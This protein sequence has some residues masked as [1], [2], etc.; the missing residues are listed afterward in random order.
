MIRI[1][2]ILILLSFLQ[3]SC[4]KE[5][6]SKNHPELVGTWTERNGE[7]TYRVLEIANNSGGTM[8]TYFPGDNDDTQFRK[9]RI[10]DNQLFYGLVNNLGE[11]SQYPIVASNDISLGFGNNYIITA[12]KKYMIVNHNYFTAE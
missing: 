1:L 3:F 12:G 11:I 7:S 8:Y 9:F 2:Y 5:K 10:K 4:K 6:I